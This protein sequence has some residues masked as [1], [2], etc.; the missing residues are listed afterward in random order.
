MRTKSRRPKE[1]ARLE[2]EARDN[3]RREKAEADRH[4]RLQGYKVTKE[5]A[6]LATLVAWRRTCADCN[7]ERQLLPDFEETGRTAR[8]SGWSAAMLDGCATRKVPQTSARSCVMSEHAL[9]PSAI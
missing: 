2:R 3:E 1:L 7:L 6:D 8:G 9:L 4:R 5:K